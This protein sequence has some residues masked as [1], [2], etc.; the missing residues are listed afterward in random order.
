[1]PAPQALYLVT[2]VVVLGLAGWV[3]AVLRRPVTPPP[4]SPGADAPAEPP[5]R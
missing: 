3:V 1:M 5:A 2:A 4:K